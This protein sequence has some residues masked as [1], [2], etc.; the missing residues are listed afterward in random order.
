MGV[1]SH[2]SAKKTCSDPSAS[3]ATHFRAFAHSGPGL[4]VGEG[5]FRQPFIGTIIHWAAAVGC[6]LARTK[7]SWWLKT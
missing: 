1:L 6:V 2:S 3:K 7:A 5:C 4:G